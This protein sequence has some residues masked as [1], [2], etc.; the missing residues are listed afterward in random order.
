MHQL[1][2]HPAVSASLKVGATNVGR[3]KLYRTIQYAAR[4]LAWCELTPAWLRPRLDPV[5]S[6]PSS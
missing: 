1:V 5:L 2:L 4:F 6:A 3:D